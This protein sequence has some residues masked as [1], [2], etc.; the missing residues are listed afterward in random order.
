METNEEYC[1]FL[2]QLLIEELINDFEYDFNC[3]MA[4]IGKKR[5]GGS[6]ITTYY[7]KDSVIGLTWH[8][9]VSDRFWFKIASRNP[10][11]RAR[12]I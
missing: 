1:K 10:K 2:E 8:R 5:F 6:N 12:N 3:K 7:F 4:Y 9:D 11:M